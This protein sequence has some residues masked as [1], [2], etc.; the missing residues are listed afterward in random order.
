VNQSDA[1]AG[2]EETRFLVGK[3][4]LA[5]IIGVSERQVSNYQRSGM[6]QVARGRYDLRDVWQWLFDFHRGAK[7]TTEV[8][9]RSKLAD[10]Q[11]ERVELDLA[12]R[13]AELFDAAQVAAVLHELAAI[14]ANEHD[15]L[16]P[17]LAGPIIAQGDPAGAETLLFS[18][19]RELR[20]RIAGRI[21]QFLGRGTPQRRRKS[22]ANGKTRDTAAT[23]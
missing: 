15:G 20:E 14:I 7:T 11:R 8:T 2:S 13:R 21:D 9:A 16:A 5:E 1:F 4:D 22:K 23:A 10:A 6:P 3:A 17:R 12:Q 18:E 19:M